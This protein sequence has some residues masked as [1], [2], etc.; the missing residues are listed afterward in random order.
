MTPRTRCRSTPPTWTCITSRSAVRAVMPS[1]PRCSRGASVR[2]WIP[3][4]ASS[5][6]ITAIRPATFRTGLL[7]PTQLLAGASLTAPPTRL[8]IQ[9]SEPVNLQQLAFQ[10]YENFQP[11][12][13]QAVYVLGA[14]GLIYHPRLETYDSTTSTATFLM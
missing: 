4:S 14:D 8:T 13:L 2:R 1:V 6:S 5:R 12:E 9:F 11:T 7:P 10:A 3:A